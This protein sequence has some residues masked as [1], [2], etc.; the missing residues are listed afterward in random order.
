MFYQTVSCQRISY[1]KKKQTT[2]T[3]FGDFKQLFKGVK[4]QCW[5]GE[6]KTELTDAPHARRKSNTQ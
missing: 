6:R 5:L 2:K 1:I 4:S 3:I